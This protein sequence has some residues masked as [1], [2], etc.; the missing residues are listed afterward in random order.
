[1]QSSAWP[2][3]SASLQ[4]SWTVVAKRSGDGA[5]ERPKTLSFDCLSPARK[6]A[7]GFDTPSG[8]FY[9]FACCAPKAP[10]PLRSAGALHNG[11]RARQGPL[12]CRTRHGL[13]W[14][15][16]ATTLLSRARRPSRSIAFRRLERRHA[17]LVRSAVSFIRW[18]VVRPKAPSPLRS[19]GALHDGYSH[20]MACYRHGLRWQSGATTP[21]SGVGKM[22]N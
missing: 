7:C 10:S 8:L 4:T 16:E 14:Q 13:R 12:A 1:M 22:M 18:L 15:S 19:A 11:F 2:A 9:S 17:A 5:F 6:K 20:A 3:S 21:L